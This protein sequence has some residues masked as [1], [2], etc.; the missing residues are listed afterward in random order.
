MEVPIF[1]AADYSNKDAG[2]KL[3]V[4]GVFNRIHAKSFPA[5]HRSLYLVIRI[6]LV[7]GEFD[8]EHDT[9]ILFVDEDGL[10]KGTYPLA[11]TVERPVTGHSAFADLLLQLEGLPLDSAGRHE[12]RLIV[13]RDVKAILPIDVVLLPANASD[14]E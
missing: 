3:N 11:F 2:G 10:E 8:I 6:E 4:L 9:K 7:L 13:N 1:L 5:R 14:P 12:F